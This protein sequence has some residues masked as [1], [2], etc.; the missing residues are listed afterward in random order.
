[1]G[2]AATH[3]ATVAREFH[4]P[5]LINASEAMAVLKNREIVT[6]DTNQGKVYRGCIESLLKA[7]HSEKKDKAIQVDKNLPLIKEVMKDISP[8]TLTEIP[9]N[10]MLEQMMKSSDFETVHD[11]IRYIHEISVREVFR[12]GGRGKTGVA[13]HLWVPALPLHFYIVDIGGGL[14]SPAVFRRNI[15]VSNIVSSP[16]ITLWKGMTCEDFSWSGS[17]EFNLEGFFS[18]VSRS[19]IQGSITDEGGKAYVLLSKDYLNFHSRLAYH[20]SVIDT[21]M[22]EVPESNYLTLRFGGGGADVNGRIQ[23]AL[24]LKEILQRLD[25]RVNVVGDTVTG[26]FRGGTLGETE[27]RL[28]QLGR[29]MAFTRQLD[30]TLRDDQTREK[31]VQAF[32]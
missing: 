31:Y 13:H 16:F 24:L 1:M 15:T 12:F 25:F 11:V 4:K 30:M 23:R 9:E 26:H 17:V 5:A 6:L 29:L 22:G 18:V 27:K 20:F 28:Y 21:L 2:S 19:F 3:L 7:N 8:L 14:D 10:P 32:L